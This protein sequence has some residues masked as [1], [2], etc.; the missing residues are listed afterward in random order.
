MRTLPLLYFGCQRRSGHFFWAPN[1][2]S[3]LYNPP[4]PPDLAN[5]FDKAHPPQG[6]REANRYVVRHLHGYTVLAFWDYSVDS[7]PGSNSAFIAPGNITDADVLAL[8]AEYFPDVLARVGQLE[9][10]TA[11]AP[12]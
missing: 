5:G 3:Y 8:A 1:G 10:V 7:R 11:P 9:S 2:R 6:T 4:I 12:A